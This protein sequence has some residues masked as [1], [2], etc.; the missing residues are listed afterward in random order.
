MARPRT[1]PEP[2]RIPD[3]DLPRAFEPATLRRSG[4]FSEARIDLD[5]GTTDAA[6]SRI[7]ES[8]VAPASV[9]SLD[10][11]GAIL[12][13]VVVDG[14]SAAELT[15]RDATWRT[16]VV[17]GG[18]IGTLDLSRARCDGLVLDGVRVDYL[19]GG[20]ATLRDVEVSGCR[21]GTLDLP[22]ARV[23]RMRFGGTSVDEMD[24]REWQ[25]ADV[26]LRGAEVLSFTDVRMLRG[27]TLTSDQAT[28]HALA[29][30]ASL[31][32]DVRTGE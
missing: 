11:T 2:P 30:A 3:P 19:T 24:I 27:V 9:H 4:G 26:D 1:R 7:S 10:L 22:G 29:L 17:R 32:I 31:G 25:A 8:V 16:V 23:E 28:S 15:A 18:R 5:P 14:V 12:A 13:D 21:I 6:H 20:G